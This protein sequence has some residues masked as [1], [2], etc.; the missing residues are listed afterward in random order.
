MTQFP[1]LELT[2]KGDASKK[3]PNF[4]REVNPRTA[5]NLKNRQQHA[6]RLNQSIQN[7]Q[8]TTEGAKALTLFLEIDPE[9]VP[10]ETLRRFNIEVVAEFEDGFILGSSAD[11]DLL[12]LRSKIER[13]L[14]GKQ[15]N[16]GGLWSIADGKRWKLDRILSPY[17]YEHW[18]EI[19]QKGRV[20]V[21]LG[22]ACVGTW[23][24]PDKPHQNPEQTHEHYQRRLASWDTKHERIFDEWE[25]LYSQRETALTTL[26][27]S[28]AG[29]V[30]DRWY[31]PEVIPDSFVIRVSVS[32]KGLSDLVHNFPFL[33]DG[34]EPE[35]VSLDAETLP[36]DVPSVLV[37]PEPPDPDALKVCIIDNSDDG[38]CTCTD[39][40]VTLILIRVVLCSPTQNCCEGL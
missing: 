35:D 39:G 30:L 34:S 16:V 40:I 27:E 23:E 17:L 14:Q 31:A 32:G 28:Y 5:D 11:T 7:I 2:Y 10:V 22:I 24:L 15:K 29:E 25:N 13:F 1:H 9:T 20:T 33:F 4:P 6:E 36:D 8:G 21:D 12:T 26:V 38:G 37:P 18:P 3:I 19:V